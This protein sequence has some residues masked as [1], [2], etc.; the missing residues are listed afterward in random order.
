MRYI[1]TRGSKEVQAKEAI[2]RGIAEDG[3]LYTPVSIPFLDIKEIK[4]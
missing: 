1:S 3:G 2:Y 4:I